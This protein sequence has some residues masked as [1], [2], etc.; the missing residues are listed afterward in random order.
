M[1]TINI[2]FGNDETYWRLNRQKSAYKARSWAELIE[3]ILDDVEAMEKD[4]ALKRK[5]GA[6]SAG[7]GS[8]GLP[9]ARMARLC[10]I[11]SRA[12]R[13]KEAD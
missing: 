3:K 2:P 8:H 12:G 1:R 11:P 4:R 5:N 7:R 6:I 9:G 10:T 13:P